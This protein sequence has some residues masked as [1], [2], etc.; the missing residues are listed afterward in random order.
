[1]MI[2]FRLG[3]DDA[4]LAAKEFGY[5]T[6]EEILNLRVGQAIVRAG[7]SQNAFNID[8]PREP[9]LPA[10]DSAAS[11]IDRSRRCYARPRADVECELA[12]PHDHTPSTGL[13]QEPDEDVDPFEDDLVR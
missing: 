6:A 11:I 1:V 13:L 7:T 4:H 5:F 9:G 2:A 12:D 8:T 10:D 3:V